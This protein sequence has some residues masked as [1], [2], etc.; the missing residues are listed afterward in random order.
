[1]QTKDQKPQGAR[2]ATNGPC[3]AC[4][5]QGQIKQQT[6]D[7]TKTIRCIQCRGTGHSSGNYQTK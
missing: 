3:R 7:G 4:G 2:G 6:K 1:M 5:G